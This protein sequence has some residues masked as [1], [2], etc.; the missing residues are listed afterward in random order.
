M[1]RLISIVS[2][3][4]IGETSETS[5]TSETI[6]FMRGGFIRDWARVVAVLATVLACDTDPQGDDGEAW[7]AVPSGRHCAA[8]AD[9]DPHWAEL[10]EQLLAQINDVR[11]RGADCHTAGNFPATTP[12]RM[13][14]ALRCAARLHSA[15]MAAHDAFDHAGDDGSSALERIAA[16][17]YVSS[18][19]GENLAAG[20]P[21]ATGTLA[22]WMASDG[23]CSNVMNPGF[24]DAGVGYHPGGSHGHLW[25]QDFAAP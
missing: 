21:D 15:D 5:E 23:H 22:Q 18:T 16:A 14:P 13:D 10:E 1:R 9:W 7:G 25:T 8:V 19:A 6:R 24:D 17:G 3:I 4:S 20:S 12:L 2:T 11:A